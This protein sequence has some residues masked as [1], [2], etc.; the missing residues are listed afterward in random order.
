MRGI[1][2]A[3]LMAYIEEKTGL[4]ISDL[5]DVFCGP[6][7]GAI[8]NAALNVPHPDKPDRPKYRARHLIRFYERE[9]A[10]IFPADRF[11][12]FR[13]LLHDFNNRTMRIGKLRQIIDHGH[14]NPEI[15]GLHLKRLLGDTRL[16]QTLKS[17]VISTYNIEG[18]QLSPLLESG[19][20]DST[21]VH[22]KN[23]ISD[24][25]GHAVWLKHIHTDL[26]HAQAAPDVSLFDAVMASTAAP[27]Y[28]PCHHF[29]AD[30]HDG[31]PA[32]AISGV[33]GSLFDNPCISYHGAVQNHLPAEGRT[34]MIL[35]G[36]GYALP[37][38][39]KE[40]WN[41]YG[42]IGIVDPA[43]DLPL[44]NIL[45][46]APESAL[47]ESFNQTLGDDLFVFNKSL[48]SCDPSHKPSRDIDDATPEN[49]KAMRD[50]AQALIEEQQ[51][52]LDRLCD[53]L[54]CNYEHNQNEKINQ[55]RDA[56]HWFSFFSH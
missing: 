25:G 40:D 9:G 28:F 43:N 36:T 31:R 21:P 8:L 32:R 26:A 51:E 16:S 4:R 55:Q 19:E 5:V 11:R 47:I 37:S 13:A 49:L 46:Q 17:L 41:S 15:L 1:I 27:T 52:R 34:I 29:S 2:P 33:D 22:T 24:E 44:I 7:T 53:L 10:H 6:S 30:F 54:V 42:N 3:S 23:N 14:Y 50:F 56:R 20:S 38:I 18:T 35:L 39:K 48:L 45:F 12:D